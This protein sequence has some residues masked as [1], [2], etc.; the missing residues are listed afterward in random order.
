[1]ILVLEVDAVLIMLILVIACLLFLDLFYIFFLYIY[2]RQDR[3]ILLESKRWTTRQREGI[4][5]I[6]KAGTCI[7]VAHPLTKTPSTHFLL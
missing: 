4:R 6:K 7:V 1:M 3:F 2:N 5:P